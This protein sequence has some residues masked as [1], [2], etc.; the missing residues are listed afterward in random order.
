MGS[1][2]NLRTFP[3][4]K[5]MRWEKKDNFR[6]RRDETTVADFDY[7]MKDYDSMNVDGFY[8]LEKARNGLSPR[9]SGDEHSPADSLISAH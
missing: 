9:T 8:K 7:G 4:W 2:R 6:H 3:G 1:L 5:K